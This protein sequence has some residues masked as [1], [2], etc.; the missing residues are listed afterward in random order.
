MTIENEKFIPNVDE[1]NEEKSHD[2]KSKGIQ[3]LL[4]EELEDVSGAVACQ[5]GYDVPNGYA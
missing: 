1:L 5:Y 2:F 3:L 4:P